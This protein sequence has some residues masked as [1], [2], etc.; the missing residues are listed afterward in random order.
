MLIVVSAVL[1]A[2][3]GVGYGGTAAARNRHTSPNKEQEEAKHW[4]LRRN[5]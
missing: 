1:N 3:G 5:A 4:L 2:T